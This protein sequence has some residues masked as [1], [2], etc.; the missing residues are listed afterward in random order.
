[1]ETDFETSKNETID[2]KNKRTNDSQFKPTAAFVS[3]AWTA[4]LIGMVSFC[5]G[6]W[7]ADM[8][9]SEKGY[10]FT[11]LLF[12][13]FSVVSVE[14]GRG[15]IGRLRRHRARIADHRAQ[16]ATDDLGEWC[17][18]LRPVPRANTALPCPKQEYMDELSARDACAAL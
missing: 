5:V 10:Y 12:G 14:R 7:N 2:F 15:E 16:V 8:W 3:A 1:M 4:L 17:T 18:W 9:L 13:L 6:L 11:L